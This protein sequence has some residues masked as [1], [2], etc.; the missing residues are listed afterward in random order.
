MKKLV[1]VIFL[2]LLTGAF[3]LVSIAGVYAVPP[4]EPI[5]VEVCEAMPLP[6]PPPGDGG[7]GL[8]QTAS[9]D[10]GGSLLEMEVYRDWR[11]ENVTNSDSR[12]VKLEVI[13]E[14]RRRK[15]LLELP[16]E[17]SASIVSGWR[18][19]MPSRSKIAYDLLQFPSISGIDLEGTFPRIRGDFASGLPTMELWTPYDAALAWANQR[20]LFVGDENGLRPDDLMTRAEL[21]VLMTRYY[22][23]V[24][25]KSDRD[26]LSDVMSQLIDLEVE[27]WL[28]EPL[29]SYSIIYGVNCDSAIELKDYPVDFSIRP[30]SLLWIIGI[31]DE[32]W[33]NL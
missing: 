31:G 32:E 23:M 1:V 10:G 30:L 28:I 22:E 8:P 3:T 13:E 15:Y 24:D 14:D 2:L 20:G 16:A 19:R 25:G 21:A 29:A 12:L 5:Q 33:K 7:E 27:D 11:N 17:A 6:E 4:P 18:E 9:G 26:K